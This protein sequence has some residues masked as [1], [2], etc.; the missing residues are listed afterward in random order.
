MA[1]NRVLI[2]GAAGRIGQLLRRELKGLYGV[3]R[4][5][6][7]APMAP[8]GAGEEVVPCDLADAAAVAKLCEGVDAIVHMGGISSDRDWDVIFPA[9]IH[10]LVNIY[11]GARVAG[12][13]RVLFA[14]SNH[15]IGMYPRSERLD[16]T[17]PA[18]PD[19]FYGLS[20]AFGEDL[21]RLYSDKYGIRSF[22]MRIGTSTD[23]LRNRRML[24]T[25]ISDGDMVR[26]IRVGL[27]A[28]YR[29]EIVYGASRNSA[30]WWD[31][32]N[33]FRLGYDPQDDAATTP[34]APDYS[35]RLE[36]PL[37][38]RFQGG[39]MASR[40]YANRFEP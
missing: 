18:R 7:V 37:T 22:N 17:S 40:G 5:S 19:C 20:K 14:S 1:L 2:T 16:H 38:E 12:T 21:G 26:L 9:N 13:D 31:N 39:V 32:G 30:G 6:D 3:L 28:D 24:S 23:G 33:A 27:E 11:E 25:W 4:L 34:R 8:A 15:A 29:Y 10:G 35:D 36:D